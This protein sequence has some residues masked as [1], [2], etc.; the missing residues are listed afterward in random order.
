MR[1]LER[2]REIVRD[3]LTAEYLKQKTHEGRKLVALEWQREV[4]GEGEERPQ[5]VEDV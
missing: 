2:V 1:K 4:E 3:S 5:L